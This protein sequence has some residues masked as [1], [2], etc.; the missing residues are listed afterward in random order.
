MIC[1]EKDANEKC[2]CANANDR[3]PADAHGWCIA[4]KC[5]AWCWLDPLTDDGTAC[6]LGP[7][8]MFI[9]DDNEPRPLDQRRG[10]C[11]LTEDGGLS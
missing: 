6:H 10:Y 1:T 4:S 3:A 11:G 5:M 7:T 2:C 9:I 8:G